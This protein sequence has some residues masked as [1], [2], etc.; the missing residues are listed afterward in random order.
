MRVPAEDRR[1]VQTEINGRRSTARGGFFEMPESDAKVHMRSAGYGA[2]WNV[3]RGATGSR[4]TG[5]RCTACGFGS[6]FTRCSRCG[7]DTCVKES[8]HAPSAAGT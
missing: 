7:T 5:Y 8:S 2:S 6:F 4:A 3:A 1:Q